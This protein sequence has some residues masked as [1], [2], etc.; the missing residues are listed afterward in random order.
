MAEGRKSLRREQQNG[1]ELLSFVKNP[2]PR[3]P[4]H[5]LWGHFLPPDTALDVPQSS[6]QLTKDWF[7]AGCG[8]PEMPRENVG[9]HL[10]GTNSVF[11]H[12]V[13]QTA[14]QGGIGLIMPS[15]PW[16]ETSRTSDTDGSIRAEP[17]R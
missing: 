7:S 16:K 12:L 14:S 3:A 15:L 6:E 11:G 4:G 5:S 2:S 17:M 9:N 1:R 10:A 8:L 13:V